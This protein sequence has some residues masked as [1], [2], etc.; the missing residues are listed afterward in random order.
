LAEHEA[1]LMPHLLI[2]AIFPHLQRHSWEWV[3]LNSRLKIYV[4][5]GLP[6]PLLNPKFCDKRVQAVANADFTWGGYMEDR[7]DIWRGHYHEPG[8]TIHLG[9]DFNVPAGTPAFLPI[10]ASLIEATYDKDQNGGWGGK[11]VFR[12][13]TDMFLMGHLEDIVTRVTIYRPGSVVGW[14]APSSRN[15]GWYPHL[16]LQCLTKYEKNVDG[17]AKAAADLRDRFPDPRNL[18]S[19]Y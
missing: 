14:V 10:G 12:N 16:H 2:K 3:N 1:G 8:H 6:N 4:R 17:Y 7:R 19:G 9:I 15:G 11:L 13:A 18:L 5:D